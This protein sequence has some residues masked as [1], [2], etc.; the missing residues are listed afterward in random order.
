MDR[1]G[2]A[3]QGTVW[4]ARPDK[5]MRPSAVSALSPRDIA[6][7]EIRLVDTGETVMRAANT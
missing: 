4:R 1:H 5:V 2:R 6:A 3:V 7:V